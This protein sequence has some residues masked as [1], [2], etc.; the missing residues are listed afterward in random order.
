LF[1]NYLESKPYANEAGDIVPSGA[2][3]TDEPMAS[4]SGTQEAMRDE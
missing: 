4:I 1:I 2:E 3:L